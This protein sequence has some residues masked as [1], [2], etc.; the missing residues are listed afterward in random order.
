MVSQIDRNGVPDQSESVS[1]FDRN[2]HME[3]ITEAALP[4]L[5]AHADPGS[6]DND[7]LVNFFDKGR[8]ISDN[9]MQYIRARILSGEANAPGSFSRRTINCV[10]ELNQPE[11]ELFTSLCGFV[12]QLDGRNTCPLVFEDNTDIYKNH[13]IT[14]SSLQHLESTGLIKNLSPLIAPM[15][16]PMLGAADYRSIA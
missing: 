12:V 14:F 2:M 16:T 3:S 5:N 15:L 6:M 11:A 1:Q 7:W 8:K 4:H 9:E 10:A 13:G